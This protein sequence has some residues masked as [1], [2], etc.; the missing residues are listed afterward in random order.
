MDAVEPVCS[1]NGPSPAQ[2]LSATAITKPAQTLVVRLIGE[3]DR[4]SLR[5]RKVKHMP[6]ITFTTPET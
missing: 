6:R 3:V 1:V 5:E 2:A 4:G